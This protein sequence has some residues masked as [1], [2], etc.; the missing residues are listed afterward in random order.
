M[1]EKSFLTSHC[2]SVFEEAVSTAAQIPLAPLSCGSAALQL[3][4]EGRSLQTSSAF[5]Y[6]FG[7]TLKCLQ[8][9]IDWGMYSLKILFFYTS[10]I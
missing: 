2:P 8:V 5:H 1:G 4:I 7:N 6:S 10:D 3:D 9:R